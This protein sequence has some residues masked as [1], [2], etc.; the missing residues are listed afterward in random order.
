MQK[1]NIIKKFHICSVSVCPRSRIDAQ[2]VRDYLVVNGLSPTERFSEAGLIVIWTCAYSQDTEDKSI[3]CIKYYLRNKDKSGRII[4]AGCLPKINPIRLKTICSL[5]T[6]PARELYKLDHMIDANIKFEDIPDPNEVRDF[7]IDTGLRRKLL[8]KEF[9]GKIKFNREFAKACARKFRES[10][11]FN[12]NRS[13][14]VRLSTMNRTEKVFVLRV[15]VGCLGQCSYCV[16]RFSKG[17]IKSKPLRDILKEFEIGLN[18]GFNIFRLVGE[19]VGSYGL[20]IDTNVMELLR[21]MFEVEGNYKLMINDLNCQC[22]IEHNPELEDTLIRNAH[23]I[24]HITLPIQSASDR[25]LR[26]MKRPYNIEDVKRCL[27]NLRSKA[28]ALNI[29]THMMVGFPSETEDDFEQSKKFIRLLKLPFVDIYEYQDRPN[30]A[31]SRMKDKVDT[32]TIK[33]RAR[34]LLQVQRQIRRELIGK[35]SVS[36]L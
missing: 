14:N 34:E 27:I 13:S 29:T 3:E 20:D 21:R 23:R 30:T 35:T 32:K 15:G 5:E 4:I 1:D 19:D 26:L 36:P 7:G 18:K 17:R 25:I 22:L 16:I 28:P 9:F 2:K 33:R 6:A 11:F 24:D 31:A 12:R 10:I 8:L